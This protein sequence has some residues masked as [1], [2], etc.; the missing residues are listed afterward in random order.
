MARKVHRAK[1]FSYDLLADWQPYA[2][3]PD[4]VRNVFGWTYQGTVTLEGVIG[5]LAHRRGWFGIAVGGSEVRELGQWER[6][7]ISQDIMFKQVA[8]WETALTYPDVPPTPAR[9]W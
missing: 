7:R 1:S 9:G 2:V 4:Q 3:P 6:I 8:G 5:A